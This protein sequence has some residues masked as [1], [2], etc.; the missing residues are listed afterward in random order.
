MVMTC[1]G[2]CTNTETDHHD[3]ADM[4]HCSSIETG[5][6]DGTEM[7]C[8]GR[9][10]IGYCEST[11]VDHRSSTKTGSSD[12]GD[13]SHADVH[14]HG[15]TCTGNCANTGIDC[16]D[17]TEMV[18]RGSTETGHHDST[19][20]SSCKNINQCKAVQ[21]NVANN[22]KKTL[23]P[24][25]CLQ[26][27]LPPVQRSPLAELLVYPTPTQ[28]TSKAKRVL[29]SVDSIALLEEKACKKERS[30]R[31]KIERKRRES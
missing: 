9:T 22:Q 1:T 21:H 13:Y 7:D 16:H 27:S 24:N 2:N 15:C 26:K 31:R 8:H 5:H 25:S 14:S 29:T 4:D 11:E 20:T 30:K 10:G 19:E 23:S 12:T 3:S 28:K 6:G 17:S 18:L